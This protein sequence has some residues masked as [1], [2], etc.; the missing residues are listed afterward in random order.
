MPRRRSFSS[1]LLPNLALKRRGPRTS[2]TVAER[3]FEALDGP[4]CPT[5]LPEKPGVR[6]VSAEACYSCSVF[7]P[8]TR[9]EAAALSARVSSIPGGRGYGADEVSHLILAP[10]S[11]LVLPAVFSDHQL[12]RVWWA[13]G[14]VFRCSGGGGV[15][16]AA[17]ATLVRAGA[18]RGCFDVTSTWSRSDAAR[19]ERG[20][21]RGRPEG[22]D[23]SLVEN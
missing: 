9:G 4:G 10:L 13:R 23:R 7:S 14:R 5:I 16:G 1:H 19:G 21:P 2:A 6:Y 15:G 20:A 17:C 22:D 8:P 3:R 18:A 11:T 12:D